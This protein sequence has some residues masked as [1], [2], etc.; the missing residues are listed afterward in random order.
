MKSLERLPH[1]RVG[2]P[3]TR[4]DLVDRGDRVIKLGQRAVPCHQDA[5]QHLHVNLYMTIL[6]TRSYRRGPL[7]VRLLVPSVP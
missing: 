6:R 4:G 2:D 3:E 5:F 7:D 1:S